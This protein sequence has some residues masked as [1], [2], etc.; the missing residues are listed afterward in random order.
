MLFFVVAAAAAQSWKTQ[1]A[2]LCLFPSRLY[3]VERA[4]VILKAAVLFIRGR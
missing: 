3:R 1:F 4:G 2:N